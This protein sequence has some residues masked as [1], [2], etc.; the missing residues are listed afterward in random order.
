MADL[1][2]L[3]S[4]SLANAQLFREDGDN[5]PNNSHDKSQKSGIIHNH[6]NNDAYDNAQKIHG[7]H[8]RYESA[9]NQASSQPQ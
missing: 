8:V 9:V 4:I 5:P 3:P 2:D 6:T 7:Q 1:F